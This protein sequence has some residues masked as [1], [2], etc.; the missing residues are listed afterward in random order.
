MMGNIESARRLRIALT[1]QGVDVTDDPDDENYDLLHVHTPVPPTNILA[2]RRAKRKGIPVVMHAHTTAED[3]EGTWTGS[4]SLSGLTGR[5]LTMFY[6][7][8]DLVLAPSAWTKAMLQARGV[9][10]QVKVLSNGVD[11]TRFRNDVDRR[12]KFRSTYSIPE[13]SLVVYSVGVMCVKKGIETFPNVAK[14][15]PDLRFVWIGRRSLLYHPLRVSRAMKQCPTNTHFIQDVDDIV[16]AHCGCD[17]FFTPSFAE[18]QGMAVMEAMSVGRTVVARDLP[19]YKD[20]LT[21][22]KSALLCTSTSEFVSALERVKGDEGL[23]RELVKE[24]QT[25]IMNHDIR[26]VA[27]DLTAIYNSLLGHPG[28]QNQVNT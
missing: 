23:A 4:T 5:Y 19:A 25:T 28:E 3:S 1:S 26:K 17:I 18:N 21:N 22:G 20:L 10:V 11:L 2:V 16:N 13:Q 14:A 15:L 24:S 27:Q 8:G 9:S 12:K 6:N 7:L